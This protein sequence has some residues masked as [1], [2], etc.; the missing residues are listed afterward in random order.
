MDQLADE[1]PDDRQDHQC[2]AGHGLARPV[3][4]MHNT[5]NDLPQFVFHSKKGGN[6]LPQM[7]RRVSPA[8]R[9]QQAVPRMAV[10]CVSIGA[11]LKFF[12]VKFG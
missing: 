1:E 8:I 4:L 5:E 9:L 7:G 11:G 10:A 6:N 3:N 12:D 2:S